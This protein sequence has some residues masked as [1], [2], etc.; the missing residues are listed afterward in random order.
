M[1]IVGKA[2][3][4]NLRDG[5]DTPCPGHYPIKTGSAACRF[6]WMNREAENQRAIRIGLII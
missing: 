5:L 1:V 3:D 2:G 4:R 6:V